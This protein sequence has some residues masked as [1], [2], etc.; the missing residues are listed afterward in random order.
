MHANL[1]IGGGPHMSTNDLVP[2]ASWCVREGEVAWVGDGEARL[3]PR[4]GKP[5]FRRVVKSSTLQIY[6]QLSFSGN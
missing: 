4:L 5:H 1:I 3:V 2:A 6:N